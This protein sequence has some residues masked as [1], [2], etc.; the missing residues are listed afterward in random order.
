MNS[1]KLTK[2]YNW[3]HSLIIGIPLIILVSLMLLNKIYGTF[4]S[5]SLIAFCILGSLCVEIISSLHLGVATNG[6]QKF[7]RSQN[8]NKFWG[9]LYFRLIMIF[10]GLSAYIKYAV[11]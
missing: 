4:I 6:F 2:I 11:S 10:I 1:K 8:P 3:I 7:E 5:I 9:F